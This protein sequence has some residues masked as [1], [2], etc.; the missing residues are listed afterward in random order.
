MLAYIALI[1]LVSLA[2]LLGGKMSVQSIPS[3]IFTDPPADVAHPAALTALRIPTHGVLINGIIYQASGEGAHPTLVICH[4]L[5]GN[6]KNLDLA[7][8]A[9][10]AGWNAVTFNYRGSWGSPGE[11]RLSQ[12][13]EDGQAVLAYLRD[14]DNAK[15]LGIDTAHIVMAGHSMG[16]WVAVYTV[17]HDHNLAG[18][19][20][21]SAADVSKQGEWPHDRLVAL[22]D[23]CTW[24]LTGVTAEELAD[25]MHAL[26]S[27]F[28]FQNM[29]SGIVEVPLLA[30]TANDGFAADTYDLIKAIHTYGGHN[31]KAI[32]F[33][34]DHNYSDHRI[35]LET[36]ILQW[37]E[38]RS[39]S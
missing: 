27:K 39:G 13:L 35:A 32:H 17:S 3:A 6:E 18:A 30:V 23:D 38:T 16:G 36:T 1:S 4:G 24:P 33:A 8:A 2:V 28:Q 12:T 10:R 9:R 21:I 19:I 22:L 37:L 11:F 5:P 31:V 26:G 29:A 7:Q 25:Q 34:T 15:R 14:R 20:L